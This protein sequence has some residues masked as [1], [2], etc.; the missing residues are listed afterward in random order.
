MSDDT[1]TM[2]ARMLAGETYHADDPQITADVARAGDLQHRLNHLHPAQTDE[3]RALLTE[4]LGTLGE[5]ADVRP[6][7]YCDLGYNLHLGARSFVNY[8]MQCADVGEIRIG[9]D[10]LIGPSVNLLTPTHPVDPE[11]RRAGW[12]GSEPITIGDNVWLGGGVTVCPGVSIGRN[13]VVGAGS[14]VV[15]DVPA[16]VVVVGNPARVVRSLA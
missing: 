14:V 12:E 3:R 5:G 16:D 13:S 7:F 2:H 6:P 10:V 4:L 11:S 15:H 9:E 1:R 8:G